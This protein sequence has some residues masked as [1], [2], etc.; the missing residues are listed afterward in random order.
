MLG[1]FGQNKKIV[2]TTIEV[3]AMLVLGQRIGKL[4]TNIEYGDFYDVTKFDHLSL[5]C[6]IL[7]QTSGTLDDLIVT[8]ERRP[9]KSVGFT[10]EQTV[11]YSVSGSV[12]EAR[13]R[14]INYVKEINYGDL[15]IKEVGFPIDI[16]LTNTKELRITARHKNGQSS[17]AN[18]N[19]IIWGRLIKEDGTKTET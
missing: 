4:T 1:Y 10:S 19:C 2:M 14:D 6:Y 15:S 18:K 11:S 17:D 7:K 5:Y 13:L 8:V 3:M 12:T 9:L 16:P